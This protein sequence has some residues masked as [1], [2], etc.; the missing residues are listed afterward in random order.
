MI[1]AV[2]EAAD[3]REITSLS[4]MSGGGNFYKIRIG[5]YRLGLSIEGGVVEFVRRLHR[6]DI[7][8]YFP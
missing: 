1:Q 2:E 7:Y 5:Q 6:R 4:K 3:L 8:R